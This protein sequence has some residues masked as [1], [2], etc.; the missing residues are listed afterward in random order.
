MHSGSDGRWLYEGGGAFHNNGAI[1][2]WDRTLIDGLDVRD[3][4]V[5]LLDQSRIGAVLLGDRFDLG[6]GPPVTAMLIQ[7]TNPMSVAPDL[8]AVHKA[9]REKTSLFACMNSS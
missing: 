8:N 6:D 3:P 5:R 7:S 4:E 2:H 1:Y 9:L